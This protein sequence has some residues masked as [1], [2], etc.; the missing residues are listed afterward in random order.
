M[1]KVKLY[2]SCKVLTGEALL[3]C[4]FYRKVEMLALHTYFNLKYVGFNINISIYMAFTTHRSW[5]RNLLWLHSVLQP[6]WS[7]LLFLTIDWW[8]LNNRWNIFHN[9]KVVSKIAHYEFAIVKSI[10]DDCN[11]FPIAY[12]VIKS[13]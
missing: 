1:K 9:W 5:V 6:F 7:R 13:Q 10:F 2:R 4:Y 3:L 8:L 11:R 12:Y